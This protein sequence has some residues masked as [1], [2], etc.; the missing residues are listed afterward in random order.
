MKKFYISFLFLIGF[1][2]VW[3]Q[4]ENCSGAVSLTN[5]ACV[6]GTAGLTQNIVGCV[7]NADDDAWYKFV[8]TGTSHSITVT[9]SATYD[10]VLQ[11][12]SGTCSALVSSACVDNTFN[13][14]VES[15]VISGLT[16]GST[17]YVRVYNYAAGSG[18]STFTICLNNPPAPPANDACSSAINLAV[19]AGC[20][21]TTGTTYGELNH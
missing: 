21:N 5:G 14:Q 18:S 9:G 1:T 3:S 2:S 7:G 10:A 6:V 20:V 12:F 11:V 19:N 8:A 17:Y 16:I 15:S 4:S 13:G